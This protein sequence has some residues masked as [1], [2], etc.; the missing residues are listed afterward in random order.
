MDDE[1]Q[2]DTSGWLA[3]TARWVFRPKR[4]LFEEAALDYELGR[5]LWDRFTGRAA[6][7]PAAGV[8]GPVPPVEVRMIP[9]HNR[10]TGLPGGT[11]AQAYLEAK[12]TLVV[13]V[14]RGLSFASCRPS[15]HYQ[16]PLV[17]SCPGL[18]EYCYLQTTLGRR[19][20]VRVYVNL[21]EIFSRARE[22][23]EAAVSGGAGGA[24]GS[25][26]GDGVGARA[27]GRG[28]PVSFEAAAVGDPVPVEPLTGAL[29]RAV[30][31]FAGLENA[32]FRFVTKFPSVEGLLGLDHRGHTRVRV[33]VNTERVIGA[34][35]HGTPGL[36]TRL[37]TLAH[38][39][40]AGY[41]VGLMVAPVMPEGNWKTEYED[42]FRRLAETLPAG[43][44]RGRPGADGGLD[45]ADSATEEA[46][47]TIEVVTHRFTESARR[48]IRER[49]PGTTLPM[50]EEGRQ[51]K[52]GQFGYFK[53]VYPPA[54]RAE[55]EELF[56]R[57]AGR[58]LP[59]A[60]FDYTV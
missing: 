51:H 35:D 14:R 38:L 44:A 19:P 13:G 26:T 37:D 30:E 42:L 6:G 48:V 25:G 46:C 8:G 59:G 4:V 52:L 41:P 43:P 17:T 23:V 3:D 9:S 45:G 58:H 28:G 57:L 24:V 2:E 31:F 1:K 10:V 49:H 60:V 47:P 29:A 34:Y 21:D 50:G 56:Q 33:T 27:G 15:A 36:A 54:L 22:L 53:Y 11:P 12:R 20:Y 7:A 55:V 32:R 40:R 16:L 5:R 39:A 18:C